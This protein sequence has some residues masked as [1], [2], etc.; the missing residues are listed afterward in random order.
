M[1]YELTHRTKRTLSAGRSF[2][3]GA[4]LN[5]QGVNFAI[6]SQHAEEVFLLL[7]DRPDGDPTDVIRLEH[8]TKFVWHA[9]VHGVKAGQCYG[10]KIRGEYNPAY[11]LRFNENKLLIDPYAKALTGKFKNKENLLLGYDPRSP[12]KD[13][14][15]DRRDNTSIVPKS[16]V[17][18]DAFDW[19]GDVPPEIPFQELI[20][21]EVHVKGFTAHPSSGVTTPGT[22]L[23]F[24]EKIPYLKKLGINA[25]ELLP[26]QVF[27]IE[28]FLLE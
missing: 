7:F 19:Q 25:V 1:A 18:D 6:Y 14:S 5:G 28:D 9:F 12:E 20:I 16:I 2:P 8:R 27:Y 17:M 13:L 24:V 21:Y 10:Y 4:T 15:Q 11:G 3:L 26:L 23:G 22:Y